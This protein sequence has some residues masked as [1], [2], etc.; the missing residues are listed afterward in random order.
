MCTYTHVCAHACTYMCVSCVIC[1]VQSVPHHFTF[2]AVHD[3]SASSP[4]HWSNVSIG[5]SIEW[6]K[7]KSHHAATHL[8][9]PLFVIVGGLDITA[10]FLLMTCGCVTLPPSCGKRYCFLSTLHVL[11]FVTIL[12]NKVTIVLVQEFSAVNKLSPRAEP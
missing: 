3:N 1:S 5:H 10:R 6:P 9:G 4:Q 2:L 7:E 11:M 12:Y 8:S